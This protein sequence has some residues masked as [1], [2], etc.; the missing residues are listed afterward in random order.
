MRG[1]RFARR[2]RARIAL[3]ATASATAIMPMSIHAETVAGVDV[4]LGGTVASNPYL[5]TRDDTGS[6]GVNGTIRPF[7]IATEDATTVRLEGILLIENFDDYGTDE[8]AEVSAS[9]LHN[10][11]ERTTVSAD[12]GFRSSE[13]GARRFYGGGN[14][15]NLQ[16]GEFPD[17][18]PIDPTLGNVSGRSSR[19]D[20]NAG[21]RQA[22]SARGTVDLS[23]GIGLTRVEG[24]F[25]QD[26]RDSRTAFS[27]AQTISERTSVRFS[28]DVGYADYFDRRAG[29]GLF[30]TTLVGADHQLSESMY[31]SFQLGVSYAD[32][33]SAL[34][35]REDL[36][37]W[38]A[39]LKLC[40]ALARGNLCLNASRS[41]Q[42]TS[43]GGITM[44]SAIGADYSRAIGI[45][46]HASF[47]ATYSKSGLSDSPVLLG[48]RKSEIAYVA[49]TYN[50]RLGDRVSAYVTPSFTANEDQF[51]GNAE[52]YQVEVGITYR[53]GTLR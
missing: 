3:L 7:V 42:P 19:L 15:D 49:G 46:G 34:G 22:V 24:A 10:L 36:T 53:F 51:A 21:L 2:L 29:D 18:G 43:L 37:S 4:S 25:G 13:A 6:V 9:I 50:H 1:G 52:N 27:Y 47:T 12:V 23:M 17:Y 31:G 45:D 38:A 40:D 32:V 44:V 33:K 41:A 28:A 11:N 14:L 20:V 5:L 8:S 39:D 35:G 30:A 16:P 48:R 26:Y